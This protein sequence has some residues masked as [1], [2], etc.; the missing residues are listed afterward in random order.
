MPEE[1]PLQLDL[2]TDYAELERRKAAEKAAEAKENRL[3]KATLVM[4]EKFGK[5]A[6][7]KGMNF[8]MMTWPEGQEIRYSTPE[9]PVCLP[10]F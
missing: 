8:D 7:L 4:Q 2:F 9:R 1:G 6:I 3:Q 10:D 5:N